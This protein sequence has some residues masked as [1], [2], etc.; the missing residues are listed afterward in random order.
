M[1]SHKSALRGHL[2]LRVQD[3]QP[4]AAG[5]SGAPSLVRCKSHSPR[6]EHVEDYRM[7][8][9]VASREV[10]QGRRGA[11]TMAQYLAELSH[12]K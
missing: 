12:T 9:G 4:K 10:G 7:A 1:F 5:C 11:S 8:P 3:L 2:D 6:G